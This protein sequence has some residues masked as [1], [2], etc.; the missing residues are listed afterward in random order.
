MKGYAN[1]GY[2]FYFCISC[3]C[4]CFVIGFRY[5][6]LFKEKLVL[7]IYPNPDIPPTYDLP[8]TS[9]L[10]EIAFVQNIIEN[11]K[12]CMTVIADLVAKDE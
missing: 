8:I 10:E 4:C 3:C 5:F 7:V 1:Y 12:D 6:L 9:E 11:D 2:K